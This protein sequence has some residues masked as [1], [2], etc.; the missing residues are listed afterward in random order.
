MGAGFENPAHAP[1]RVCFLR[2]SPAPWVY[3]LKPQIINQADFVLFFGP[4]S[5]FAPTFETVPDV[6]VS[7]PLS[8]LLF[9]SLSAPFL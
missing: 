2:L 6:L 5:V 7:F 4:V 1:G 9:F 3:L 8:P